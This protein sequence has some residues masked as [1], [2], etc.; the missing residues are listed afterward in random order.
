MLRW[1]LGDPW[2]SDRN[3]L[4]AYALPCQILAQ[5]PAGNDNPLHSSQPELLASPE[6]CLGLNRVIGIH[7]L[8]IMEHEVHAL[9][10]GQKLLQG[11]FECRHRQIESVRTKTHREG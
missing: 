5:L 7:R 9:G 6:R 1:Y 2:G 3:L 10:I 8:K 4:L 11:G